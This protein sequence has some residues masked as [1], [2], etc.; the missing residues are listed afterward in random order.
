MG[1]SP[2]ASGA[3][4]CGCESRALGSLMGG[5]GS[6]GVGLACGRF[7]G[8]DFAFQVLDL[9]FVCLFLLLERRF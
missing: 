9:G 8:F 5:R 6:A 7:Q 4:A 1:L 3:V 2:G